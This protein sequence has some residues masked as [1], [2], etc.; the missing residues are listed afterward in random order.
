MVGQYNNHSI[1][2][3]VAIASTDEPSLRQH[4]RRRLN[5]SHDVVDYVN[6]CAKSEVILWYAEVVILTRMCTVVW[7]PAS[8]SDCT[9]TLRELHERGAEDGRVSTAVS[10]IT[11]WSC[12]SLH[13]Q[14][15][16]RLSPL[17]VS[18]AVSNSPSS[19]PQS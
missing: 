1:I 16:L 17:P 15:H 19:F 3:A 2:M 7:A 13:P 5:T 18:T 12:H 9:A 14:Q 6:A 10:W 8:G 4:F 11:A